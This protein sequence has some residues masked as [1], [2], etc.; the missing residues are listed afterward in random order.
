M[1]RRIYKPVKRIWIVVSVCVLIITAAALCGAWR[2]YA[3]LSKALDGR[4]ERPAAMT[5]LSEF[6]LRE[7][8]HMSHAVSQM[9][10]WLSFVNMSE[11]TL[12]DGGMHRHAKVYDAIREEKRSAWAL[13]LHGG[14]GT[15]HNQIL[16]VACEFSLA[17]Y[18][19]LT[20]DL[21]SHGRSE[22]DLTSLGLREQAD[23]AAWMDWIKKQDPFAEI[24]IWGHD[25]GAVSVLLAASCGMDES[26]RAIIADSPYLSIEER[27]MQML[28]ESE[29][30]ISAMDR[31]LAKLAYRAMFGEMDSVDLR[32][33][34]SECRIPILLIYGSGDEDT[35]AWYGEE[36]VEAADENVSLMLIEGAVHGMARY[37]DPK[38]YY[39]AIMAHC[40]KAF[41]TSEPNLE[42]G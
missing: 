28:E 1:R 9:N 10:G 18:R 31:F 19:V 8:M 12:E 41:E 5:H 11:V 30:E 42:T 29:K 36:L 39:G 35:P 33:A 6:A 22:G 24:V 4:R 38:A 32:K 40:D 34:V 15:D 7:Q 23:V 20:P 27:F 14:L 2:G 25:E 17:G 3:L 26:V 37:G 16:D 13:V 21:V